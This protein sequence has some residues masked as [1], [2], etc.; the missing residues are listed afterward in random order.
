MCKKK[1]KKPAIEAV[2][3]FDLTDPD[4][5]IAHARAVAADDMASVLWDFDQYLRGEAKYKGDE[6]AEK[7][8]D[9]LWEI[10]NEHG[11]DLDVLWT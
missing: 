11:I 1:K 8:R 2:I 3:T 5:K 4:A 6:V 10:M 9:K 7:I